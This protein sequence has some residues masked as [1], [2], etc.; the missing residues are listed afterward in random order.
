MSYYVELNVKLVFIQSKS[1]ALESREEK[2]V[3]KQVSL[4][5]KVIR[6][7]GITAVR[8]ACVFFIKKWILAFFDA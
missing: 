7:T 8:I 5:S 6:Q 3:E 4:G 2:R 1:K